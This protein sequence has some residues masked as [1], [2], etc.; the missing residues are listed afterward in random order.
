MMFLRYTLVLILFST[1][2]YSQNNFK[3]VVV[4]ANTS[5]PVKNVEIFE[6]S[7]G[8][9][10]IT[11]ADGLFNITTKK[12]SLNLIFF[13]DN[14]IV[15]KLNVNE[16]TFITHKIYPLVVD[17]DDVEIIVSDF[18]T[19]NL[20]RLNDIENT[21][22]YSGKKTEV[23]KV[24]Q[25]IANLATNNARQI[26]SQISGLNVFQ[27]DD[28]GLQLNIGGRGL[29]P[30]RTSNFNTRQNGYDIS[31]DVLGYPESYYT[32]P[33]EAIKE[34]Q[35]IRG[36]ASLQYGTQFGGLINFVLKEPNYNKTIEVITRNTIGS[37]K[38]FTNFTSI[39]GRKN[40]ISYYSFFNYKS[41]NGFRPN[42]NFNST[43]FYTYLQYKVNTRLTLS[44]EL[45][46]MNYLTQQA[47]GLTDQMF[48]E[49]PL[50]SNR[51]RNWF[52]VDWL[53]YNS[54]LNYALSK[55]TRFSLNFFGLK[56]QR[57]AL[58][59]RTNR[60]NQIDNGGT[61]DL[62][63][64][65]FQNYGLES[66][67]LH[68][69]NFIN[70]S[71]A[72]VFGSKLYFS[73]NNSSQGAGSEGSDNDF[74]PYNAD[75]PYYKNQSEYFYPN[76]N[77]SFFTENLIYLN[78]KL[79]I[80]PGIRYEYI[81]TESNG[82]YKQ[83]NLDAASNPIFDTTIYEVNKNERQFLLAGLGISYKANNNLESYSNISQNY[84]SVTFSDIS[85][86]SPTYSI[87]PDIKDEQ[88]YTLD[89]GL[90]G[91]IKDILSYD[92]SSFLVSYKDRIGFVQ[93]EFDFGGVKSVRDNVGDAVLYGFESI[94]DLNLKKILSLSDQNRLNVFFNLSNIKSKYVD[95]D[96]P[97]I[98]G[99]SIEYVPKINFKSGIKF[100]YRKFNS[101]LQF[102]YLSEQFSDAS[103]AIKGNSSGIIGAIPKYSVV[104]LS[105][106][107]RLK[108]IKFEG[109]INNLIDSIYYNR[110]AVGYPGPGIIP[111]PRRNFYLSLEFVL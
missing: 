63:K 103:N 106:S 78:E 109:G 85:I 81:K 37:N 64:G 62:I 25:A 46:Y 74:E 11:N 76:K 53:L 68:K 100:G 12:E 20:G 73:K 48:E 72:F 58:G 84:R 79:S 5:L 55:K 89:L 88:G 69:Y 21:S 16:K 3:G 94:I 36:A 2:L 19:F 34:I 49:D 15:S 90:R 56:A 70:K 97:G 61:R 33:P 96:E 59:Y 77:I 10:N 23:I 52:E 50:Q 107:Y 83:I 31:A 29:D 101:S 57:S 39:S 24:N 108:L 17:L 92:V 105:L 91:N 104:D 80:T 40:K 93:R 99:N 7:L 43:N 82:F 28:A 13:C 41:G 86:V 67:I 38:L 44:S 95:S 8:F 45:T 22:M 30:N 42:S 75:F 6:E 110:R 47:G 102:S 87:D 4:S 27:N 26:Y 9:L 66:K 32:P 60:V 54:K 51:S 35:I 71:A 98:E 111:S 65:K 1:Q 18:E 14:Y